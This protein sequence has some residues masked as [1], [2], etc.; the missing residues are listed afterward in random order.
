M[1]TAVPITKTARI[2]SLDQFRGYTV[3]AM[4][5]V[6]YIGGFQA[7]DA[8]LGPVEG[9]FEHHNT[10]FSYADSVM[11]AFHFAVGF[12][13]RLTLLRRLAT[14]GRGRAYFHVVRRC[15]GLILLSTVLELASGGHIPTWQAVQKTDWREWGADFFKCGFWETL[16]IIGVTSIWV[17][18]VIGRSASTRLLFIAGSLALHLVLS[19]LFYFDFLWATPNWLDQWWGAAG[20][21]GLDGGPLGFLMW[22]VCQL[23]GSLAYDGIVNTRPWSAVGRLLGWSIVLMAVGYAASCLTGL[24]DVRQSTAQDE[25][26]TS[27]VWPAQLEVAGQD[28]KEMLAEPP[29]VAPPN[30]RLLNY[31]MMCK[32]ATTLSFI[33]FSSGFC[34]AIYAMFVVVSDIGGL[35]VGFFRTFGSNALAA[36]VIHEIVENAVR[37]F[38]PNDSPLPWALGSFAI[39]AGITYLFVC[40]LEKKGIYLRM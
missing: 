9:V 36:Y 18:P 33:L 14:A 37:R 8:V 7:I 17:L 32:R 28:R 24:Y 30:K 20:T 15:L 4:I 22:G 26:A 23:I 10:Y 2:A 39:F 5:L 31:W 21:K 11:P 38:A 13:L 1:A 29:F 6:N 3:A 27:P 12:A 40:H 19:Y 25:I 35:E 16:A 34:L